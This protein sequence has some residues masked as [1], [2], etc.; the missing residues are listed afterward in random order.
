MITDT[1]IN[2][3]QPRPVLLTLIGNHIVHSEGLEVL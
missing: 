1:N 3:Q 2:Y